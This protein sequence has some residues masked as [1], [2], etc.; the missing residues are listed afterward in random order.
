MAENVQLATT[1]SAGPGADGSGTA[2]LRVVTCQ[3]C[4]L[5][6]AIRFVGDP[7]SNCGEE[8]TRAV[9]IRRHLGRLFGR[10]VKLVLLLSFLAFLALVVGGFLLKWGFERML[11]DSA[12][13]GPPAVEWVEGAQGSSTR[14]LAQSA[15]GSA[16]RQ[17]S[18]A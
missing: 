7:C 12:S 2:F 18:W 1:A 10:F 3:A 6:V 8:A 17:A 14:K 15:S 13:L 9:G 16:S 5:D 11:D 4:G